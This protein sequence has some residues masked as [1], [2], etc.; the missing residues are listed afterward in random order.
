MTAL[1]ITHPI[2]TQHLAGVPHPESTA[3][4][5]AV[6]QTLRDDEFAALQWQEAP[7]AERAALELVHNAA[8][9]ESVLEAVPQEGIAALDADT[10]LSPQSVNAALRAVGAVTSAVDQVITGEA[11]HA[12]CAVRPPGHHAE[13]GRAMGFCLFNSIA[14]GARHAQTAH[15]LKKIAI[16]DFDV[17]HGNGT[18]AAFEQDASVFFASTH[19][20]PLY[21][22]TGMA[23]ERGVGNIL[24]VPLP[25]GTIGAS[26]RRHFEH[27][28]L[29]ALDDFAPDF[30]LVSAG[31]DAHRRDPLAQ[32][33][34]EES[35]F[36]WITERLVEVAARK[37]DGRLVSV[38]EGGYDLRGLSDS[39][40]AHMRV[41]MHPV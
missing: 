11:A 30:L 20:Y 6:W 25:P 34:L 5:E 7:A 28:V 39:V 19:Q 10:L 23:A 40:A 4:I 35:D 36:G 18:Q 29:P 1:V 22:G 27:A 41:L 3:R 2:F 9:I 17:H 15:G 26:Y 37:C 31:F 21:P 8:E 32:M 12:F 16:V 38:L 33:E 13:P 14:I 24:N